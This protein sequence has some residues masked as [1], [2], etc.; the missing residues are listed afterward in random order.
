MVIFTKKIVI[1]IDNVLISD[2]VV[3]ARF[4]CDLIKCKGGC[5]E[6]GD[7]GAPLTD[8]ETELLNEVF[9]EVKPYLTP[10][11]LAEIEKNG[12]YLYNKD[13]GWV[14]PTINDKMCAYGHYD[15]KGI[16]KCGIEQAYLDGKTKWRKPV[17]CHLFPIKIKKTPTYELVNYE[18]RETL[19]KPACRLG[20]KLNM[21]VYVFLKEAL[22]R[23][24]G[25]DFYNALDQI[26]KE[27]YSEPQTSKH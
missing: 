2:E 4:V 21:P 24:F 25:D 8:E 13:F 23:K 17:S 18:P 15:R 3:L 19:C 9:E 20:E 26:A 5:C 16:I 12:R 11:G 14:T 10:D 22:I 27:Y 6:D 1:E 7:A